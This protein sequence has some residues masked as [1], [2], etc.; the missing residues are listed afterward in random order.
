MNYTP[1]M[2]HNIQRLWQLDRHMASI[3]CALIEHL[4]KQNVD[5]GLDLGTFVET[6]ENYAKHRKEI[7]G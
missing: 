4:K 6:A 1:E 7:T 5:M 3:A 2:L